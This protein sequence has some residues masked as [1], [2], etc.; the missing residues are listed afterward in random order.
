MDRISRRLTDLKQD[1]IQLIKSQPSSFTMR[2]GEEVLYQPKNKPLRRYRKQNG[3]LWYSNMIKDGNEYVD[4]NLQVKKDIILDG[5]LNLRRIPIFEATAN[6][7]QSNLAHS[8]QVQ[9]EFGS[10]NIDTTSSF[11]SHTFTAP[12]GGYYMFY[13]QLGF[14]AFDTGMSYAMC[15]LR[16]ES[17]D[18]FC[19]SRIDDKEFTADTDA[20]V[21]RS[22]SAVKQLDQGDTV[23][24]YWFQH[25]GTAQ[26]D[27]KST[28]SSAPPSNN[29]RSSIF[30]GYFISK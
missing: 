12:V 16:R 7:D 3:I 6:S 13:Y 9:L 28:V 20:V 5:Y 26:V 1:K 21:S 14:N 17:A 22:G 19:V 8:S 2:E 27:F 15:G 29:T 10:E 18:Y 30:G 25:S 24:V 11:A 4:K 23:G